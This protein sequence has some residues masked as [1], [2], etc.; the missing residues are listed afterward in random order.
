M[1]PTQ[2]TQQK[3]S[4]LK[5]ST[6]FNNILTTPSPKHKASPYNAIKSPPPRNSSIPCSEFQS[7][8]R[9]KLWKVNKHD[10][11]RADSFTTEA[12]DHLPP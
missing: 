9:S 5:N 1:Q 3:E 4:E 12:K 6:S 11:V 7:S 8:S 10:K 2:S